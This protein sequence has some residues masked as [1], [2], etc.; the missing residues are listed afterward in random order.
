MKR[1]FKFAMII[2]LIASIYPL[3][4]LFQI[5][6]SSQSPNRMKQYIKKNCH[7]DLSLEAM[8][9]EFNLSPQYV[10]KIFKEELGISYI[11]YL[12]K[13]R[14]EKAKKMMEKGSF[15]LKEIVFEVGYNDPNY[16]SSV[17]KKVCK[18]SPSQYKDSLLAN[19][20]GQS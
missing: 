2:F 19:K 10:S 7:T 8:A 4:Q 11:D 1:R 14:I 12:I 5:Y 20:I 16:F 15:S 3:Y 9:K 6:Q 17:F 13:C 18:K